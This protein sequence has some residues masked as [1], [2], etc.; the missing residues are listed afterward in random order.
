MLV[1]PALVIC[2]RL[3]GVDGAAGAV[4]GVNA[5]VGIPVIAMVMRLFHVSIAE[6]L[7]SMARPG[8]GWIAMTVA[9]LALQPAVAG[10][11]PVAQLVALVVVG[12]GV[13]SL[14]IALFA[15]TIVTNMWLSLRGTRMS[16]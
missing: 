16:S 11:S 5:I 7:G 13:Y 6:L 4:V 12:G 15:R 1:V 2:S 9:L 8:I 14:A 10:F 3:Y